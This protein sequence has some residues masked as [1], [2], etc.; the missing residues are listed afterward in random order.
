VKPM[1]KPGHVDC[2]VCAASH[3]LGDHTLECVQ[4][5]DGRAM[6]GHPS[7]GCVE[8]NRLFTV[9]TAAQ[10]QKWGHP[11]PTNAP[12]SGHRGSR[13]HVSE[14]HGHRAA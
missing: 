8:A 12:P 13:R 7:K 5:M 1:P 6:L 3:A 2:P 11:E 4:C 14:K 10:L 9:L